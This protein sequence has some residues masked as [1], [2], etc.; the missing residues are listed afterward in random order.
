MESNNNNL[1]II[2]A[3]ALEHFISTINHQPNKLCL[4]ILYEAIHHLTIHGGPQMAEL[5][6]YGILLDNARTNHLES[7]TSKPLKE[8][9]LKKKSSYD[10][11]ISL[12]NPIILKTTENI[13]HSIRIQVSNTLSQF[14]SIIDQKSST[15]GYDNNKNN[16]D[17][18]LDRLNILEEKFN[19]GQFELKDQA[20]VFDQEREIYKKEISNLKQTIQT[21]DR[22]IIDLNQKG[23][24]LANEVQSQSTQRTILTTNSNTAEE[25]ENKL[26]EIKFKLRNELNH[27]KELNVQ[28]FQDLTRRC[29]QKETELEELIK[30]VNVLETYANEYQ[31]NRLQQSSI[32]LS[33]SQ[34]RTPSI[35]PVEQTQITMTPPITRIHSPSASPPPSLTATNTNNILHHHQVGSN[36]NNHDRRRSIERDQHHL[37]N[38]NSHK[39]EPIPVSQRPLNQ[40]QEPN[41]MLDQKRRTQ[42]IEVD[43]MPKASDQVTTYGAVFHFVVLR[44]RQSR[45]FKD[46]LI[47][48][49]DCVTLMNILE[50]EGSIPSLDFTLSTVVT[51]LNELEK[52][53]A[54]FSD[55]FNDSNNNNKR[56]KKVD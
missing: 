25:L 34:I 21:L 26:N 51:R 40:G 49:L 22:N 2:R 55:S 1:L 36:L 19:R 30:R 38:P 17:N 53:F 45:R 46:T 56:R 29:D 20:K 50:Q 52:V 13:E 42:Q 3:Q 18:I 16:M 32:S 54:K 5:R 35:T 7:P 6:S 31:P 23:E 10:H 37:P 12:L 43:H 48:C 33:S 9:Y 41:N 8:D 11:V 24:R 44:A 28:V 14:I 15:S 27:F 4:Q 39:K 47:D